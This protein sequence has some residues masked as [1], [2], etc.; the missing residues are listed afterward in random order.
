M[1]ESLRLLRESAL[2]P[3]STGSQLLRED[4]QNQDNSTQ[5]ELQTAMGAALGAALVISSVS[6]EGGV[7]TVQ[8]MLR[9]GQDLRF[10]FTNQQ[11]D[12]CYVTANQLELSESTATIISKLQ[13]Y[14]A[15]W[16][17]QVASGDAAP[18]AA[19]PGAGPQP[20]GPTQQ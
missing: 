14:H 3:R 2:A 10:T 19:G 15:T 16:Y 8:G 18:A 1:R 4:L 6:E 20:D 12:G 17:T 11:P 9:L 13:A 5:Q 7:T